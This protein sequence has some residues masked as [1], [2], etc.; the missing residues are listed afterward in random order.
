MC[1]VKHRWRHRYISTVEAEFV[2]KLY[3]SLHLCAAGLHV[4]IAICSGMWWYLEWGENV[5]QMNGMQDYTQLISNTVCH[6]KVCTWTG[7][8]DKGR[9]MGEQYKC[10]WCGGNGG[11]VRQKWVP[12]IFSRDKVRRCVEL[13]T[14]PPS[15]ADCLKIWKPQT[16]GTLRFVI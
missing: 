6:G 9:L 12:G 7:L 11:F 2:Q 10:L 1:V 8:N 4:Y 3:I 15:S 14:L 16:L 13:T 5:R